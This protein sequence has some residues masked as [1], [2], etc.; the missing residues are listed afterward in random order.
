KVLAVR[1]DQLDQVESFAHYGLEDG[2]I[3]NISTRRTPTRGKEFTVLQQLF[4]NIGRFDAP[5]ASGG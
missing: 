1:F 2:Q 5:G 4:S 3:I